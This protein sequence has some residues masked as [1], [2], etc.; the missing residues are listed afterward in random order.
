MRCPMTR[1]AGMKILR[2]FSKLVEGLTMQADQE[3]HTVETV[4]DWLTHV[5]P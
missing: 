5:N 4:T 2:R 1:N 3:R